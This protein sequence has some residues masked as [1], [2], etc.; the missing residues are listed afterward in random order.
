MKSLEKCN[1]IISQTHIYNNARVIRLFN[2]VANI[3]ALQN[4]Q[5]TEAQTEYFV[6]SAYGDMWFGH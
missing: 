2:Y 3:T 6:D 1:N 5:N 4:C